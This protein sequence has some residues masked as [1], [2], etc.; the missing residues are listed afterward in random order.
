MVFLDHHLNDGYRWYSDTGFVDFPKSKKPVLVKR[1]AKPILTAEKPTG[2]ARFKMHLFKLP[3]RQSPLLVHYVGDETIFKDFP[4]KSATKEP[5]R[6]FIR[7]A[8]TIGEKVKANMDKHPQELYQEM[9]FDSSAG[10]HPAYVPRDRKQLENFRNAENARIRL[11]HD[12]LYNL[13]V[14]GF[15]YSNFIKEYRVDFCAINNL[16]SLVSDPLLEKLNKLLDP[17]DG[18]Y[19]KSLKIYYDT[20]FNIGNYYLSIFSY[21]YYVLDGDPVIP[22]AFL[23]HQRKFAVDHNS[24]LLKLIKKCPNLASKPFAFITDREFT[25]I[26]SIF[27]KA[28]AFILL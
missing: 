27:P 5:K 14:L 8:P 15:E 26:S 13:Y 4:H 16:V 2:D 22:A 25:N 23:I 18:A 11:S 17:P 10:S 20:T 19:D 24:F 21:R 9:L 1:K 3:M 12:S 28:C 6:P 7:S